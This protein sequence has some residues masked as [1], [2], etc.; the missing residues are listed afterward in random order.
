MTAFR[1]EVRRN[2]ALLLTLGVALAGYAALMGLMYPIVL[3]NEE[4]MYQYMEAFP[5]GFLAAFGMDG[6]LSDHGVFFNTYVGSWL[7]PIIAA[8]AGLIV[9]TRAVA[10][11]L[12][13][14]FLDLPLA[15]RA[16]RVRYLG[17]S[18]GGQVLLIGLLALATVGAM[19][20]AGAIAGAGF[21]LIRFL[22]GGLLS[23]AFGCAIAGATTL[24]AVVT[25][26]R[27]VT[28]AIVGGT[29]VAMYAIFVVTQVAPD[30]AWLAPLSAWDH[31]RTRL[32]IDE[33]TIPWADLALFTVIA[34]GGWVGALVAFRRRDLAA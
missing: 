14:G 16:S 11:D 4:L 20:V 19:W 13:R 29:L 17:A 7:W 33:G 22:L 25:L 5:K 31:F 6:L 34:V 1:L 12:D 18:I 21:D 24:V 32:L 9:G 2:R 27:G 30:W 3:E 8:V 28:C 15:T 26:S 10:A 23:F